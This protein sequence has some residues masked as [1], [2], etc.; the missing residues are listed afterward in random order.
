MRHIKLS[1]LCPHSSSSLHINGNDSDWGK[2]SLKL[3][4]AWQSA[5]SSAC[6]HFYVLK[7]DKNANILAITGVVCSQLLWG[8]RTL[9]DPAF[10]WQHP[11]KPCTGCIIY[12][13]VLCCVYVLCCGT[14]GGE[15]TI[16]LPKVGAM[17]KF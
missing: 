9:Q 11:G 13:V 16:P 2:P 5:F 3:T 12:P 8:C 15:L 1:Q 17:W 6:W 10:A 4:A 7:A 14:I